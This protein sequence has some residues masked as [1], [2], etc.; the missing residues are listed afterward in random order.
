MPYIPAAG[1]PRSGGYNLAEC[2]KHL[3]ALL[4]EKELHLCLRLYRRCLF[5]YSDLS[6]AFISPKRKPIYLDISSAS[7][8]LPEPEIAKPRAEPHMNSVVLELGKAE[9]WELA[10]RTGAQQSF[11]GCLPVVL[12]RLMLPARVMCVLLKEPLHLLN[13]PLLQALGQLHSLEYELLPEQPLPEPPEGC[14]NTV[15]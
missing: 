14:W 1:M 10:V 9:L 4:N 7:V 2:S 8:A 6:L 12:D 11:V 13:S 15:D 3:K 5:R